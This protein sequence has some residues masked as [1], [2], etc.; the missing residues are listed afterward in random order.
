MNKFDCDVIKDL[1]PLYAD[2]VCSEKSTECVEEHLQECA[3]CSEELRKIKECPTVP[4]V[5]EDLKKAVKNA[6]K[7][8][9]KGKKKTVI[10]T[11]ALVLIL[12]ILFGV[13]GMYRFILYGAKADHEVFNN[14]TAVFNQNCESVSVDLVNKKDYENDSVTLYVGEKYKIEELEES[15]TQKLVINKDKHIHVIE[16]DNGLMV[17]GMSEYLKNHVFLPARPFVKWGVKLMGYESDFAPGYDLSLEEKILEMDEPDV[18][19]FCSPEDYAKA[20]AYYSIK[21]SMGIGTGYLLVKNE[22]FYCIGT[23][24]NNGDNNLYMFVIQSKTDLNKSMQINFLGYE[25]QEEV[26]EVLSS[27]KFK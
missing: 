19:F 14:S 27:L 18:P 7:R 12:V 17:Y 2:N 8:I 3:E 20:L 16:H 13:I 4:A 6:G 22:E 21:N 26:V 1:L 23:K 9:K 15:H 11:V 25:S 10:E 24:L 5:D